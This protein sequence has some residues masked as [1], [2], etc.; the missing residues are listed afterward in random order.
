[1]QC[2]GGIYLKVLKDEINK[3]KINGAVALNAQFLF[4][5]FIKTKDQA[6]K[7]LVFVVKYIY[8]TK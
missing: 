6:I 2:L 5:L 3:R 4:Y 1:M 8:A 7:S